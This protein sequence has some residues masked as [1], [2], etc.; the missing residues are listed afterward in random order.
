MPNSATVHSGDPS[1]V[2]KRSEIRAGLQLSQPAYQSA[3]RLAEERR[4][5]VT[6]SAGCVTFKGNTS[7]L[8][9]AGVTIAEQ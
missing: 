6:A 9:D 7:S 1:R 2:G 8:N 5:Y 3:E 4:G